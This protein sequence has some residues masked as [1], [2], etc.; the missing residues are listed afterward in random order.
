[1]NDHNRSATTKGSNDWENHVVGTVAS[2][3]PPHPWQE[4]NYSASRFA[5]TG[6]ILGGISGCTSLLF[7]IIGS[8]LWPSLSG[9]FQHPLH[10]IQVYLTFPLGPS[11]LDLNVGTTLAFGCILYL[12]TGAAYGMLFEWA[13][14]YFLPKLGLP[15]RLVWFSALAVLLWF[16][17]FYGILFWLQPL[18]F[19]N[20]LIIT[21]IPWWVASLT[22]LVFGWTMAVLYPLENATAKTQLNEES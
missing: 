13:L 1:M 11:A 19:K 4:A 6:L 10:L 18:L 16:V 2:T 15:G 5:K 12:L 22:H 8:V 20:R 9:Q 14:S 7:N 21:L 17:N 3:V